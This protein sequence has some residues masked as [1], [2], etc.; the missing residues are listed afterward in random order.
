MESSPICPVPDSC[1]HVTHVH[2]FSQ[3]YIWQRLGC[4]GSLTC[5]KLPGVDRRVLLGLYW[6]I[7]NWYSLR[8]VPDDPFMF[9]EHRSWSW[10][11]L[12]KS[13]L[14]QP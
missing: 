1:S 4:T 2:I 7:T 12:M 10:K 6:L 11:G 9:K 13:L 5:I 8:G 14:R 3:Q